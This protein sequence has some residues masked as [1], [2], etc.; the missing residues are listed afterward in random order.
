V[1]TYATSTTLDLVMVGVNFTATDMTAMAS[2][3]ID[4]AEA[5]VNRHLSKRYDISSS[6]FQT[7][8]SVPPIVRT[9]AERLAEGYMW[10]WMARGSK[11]T[12]ERGEDLVESAV[13]DLKAIAEY[14]MDLLDTAGSAIP[15]SANSP[16]RVQCN[17]SDYASTFNED[18]EL[19]WAQDSTKLSDI[20]DERD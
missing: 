11:E 18:D 7:S 19:S 15:E 10:T 8:T 13:E 16:F 5:Q 12:L 14:K 20:S 9:L 3:A 1:G 6:T 17:T 2:K 4:H